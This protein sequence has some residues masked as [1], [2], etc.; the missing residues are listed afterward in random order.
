MMQHSHYKAIAPMK[1]NNR[2]QKTKS[3]DNDPDDKFGLLMQIT[4]SNTKEL[5]TIKEQIG[6]NNDAEVD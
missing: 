6:C 5:N 1:T 2:S 3:F 4:T